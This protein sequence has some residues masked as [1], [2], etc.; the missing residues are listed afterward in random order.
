MELDP[1][2]V[3]NELKTFATKFTPSL[4]LISLNN[5]SSHNSMAQHEKIKKKIRKFSFK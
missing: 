1:A 5:Y 3:L 2:A 4:L